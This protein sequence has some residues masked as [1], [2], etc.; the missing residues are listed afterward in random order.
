M[1]GFFE[2]SDAGW[3]CWAKDA[4]VQVVNVDAPAV[5]DAVFLA[6]HHSRSLSRLRIDEVDQ[7]VE[8]E[9][10]DQEVLLTEFLGAEAPE[11]LF[12]VLLG[13]SG[14]GKSHLVRWVLNEVKRRADSRDHIVYIAKTDMSLRRVV[15]LTIE[16]LTGPEID[17]VRRALD[18]VR[19]TV[20][21]ELAPQRLLEFL[22][23]AVA[24]A[25]KADGPRASSQFLKD[26]V[27]LARDPLFIDHLAAVPAFAAHARQ[28]VAGS[29]SPSEDP[30]FQFT[31][32]VLP[33]RASMEDA[34]RKA[35]EAGSRHLTN[36]DAREKLCQVFNEFQPAAIRGMVGLGG[37]SLLQLFSEVRRLLASGKKGGKRLLLFIEDLTVL[38]GIEHEFAD[39]LTVPSTTR[40]R[41]CELR[42]LAASTDEN[43]LNSPFWTMQTVRTRAAS[44]GSA[45]VLDQTWERFGEH[46]L[47]L[48]LG[49]YLN[50]VRVGV[51]GLAHAL[52]AGTPDDDWVPNACRECPQSRT[53]H[54]L[55]GKGGSYGL[56]PMNPDA[57]LRIRDLIGADFD[58][59]KLLSGTREA[60]GIENRQLLL[61]GQF[62]PPALDV[63]FRK[64]EIKAGQG[65]RI[66][67]LSRIQE[68]YPPDARRRVVTFVEFWGRSAPSKQLGRI[69]QAFGLDISPLLTN[70]PPPPPPPPTPWPPPPPPPAVN[71]LMQAIERWRQGT[72]LSSDH[73]G[74][75]RALVFEH[76]RD[77][78]TS[79]E[80]LAPS[81][82]TEWIKGK[83]GQFLNLH[84]VVLHEAAGGGRDTAGLWSI[85]LRPS[86]L[87]DVRLLFGLVQYDISGHWHFIDGPS[88]FRLYRERFDTW[89]N[90][91]VDMIHRGGSSNSTPILETLASVLVAGSVILGLAE[92]PPSDP[93][94]RL[95]LALSDGT[96]SS[97][98]TDEWGNPLQLHLSGPDP[99]GKRW[100]RKRLLEEVLGRIGVRQGTSGRFRAIDGVELEA[101][102][103]RFPLRKLPTA[104]D[105]LPEG[106]RSYWRR[107]PQLVSDS[108]DWDHS[109]VLR[110][111]KK[112]TESLMR[113]VGDVTEFPALLDAMDGLV[114][115]A[116][117]AGVLGGVTSRTEWQRTHSGLD[118]CFDEL[119]S[120]VRG[121]A[122]YS[123]LSFWHRVMYLAH[124]YGP[125]L[126]KAADAASQCLT[127]FEATRENLTRESRRTGSNVGVRDGLEGLLI[128]L[129]SAID[130]FEG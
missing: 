126:Q 98:R 34:G 15:E 90:D 33:T 94:H 37:T 27:D 115:A 13:K 111:W 85:D 62:P 44:S 41:L 55:F 65:L 125:P 47:E 86:E 3:V 89:T 124:D 109:H 120:A 68:A 83:G 45:F 5:D 81:G 21:P 77:L 107:I 4:P 42:V 30:A 50:A 56:Y 18:E 76:L 108:L 67:L 22:M 54:E 51:D 88:Y 25:T 73:A 79:A 105:D 20:P 119:A 57:L 17:K 103:E 129:K 113:I 93:I 110:E 8:G 38:S 52:H 29:R 74:Q 16:G 97:R 121:L 61:T 118:G 48:F 66:D 102:L 104:S 58:P 2:K 127:V 26:V 36:A 10:A 82:A 63:A 101:A 23:M 87:N 1:S 9:V 19:K 130:I 32:D 116:L 70:A 64:H 84:S 92:S 53:C 91:L 106:L 49:R 72:P 43:Y 71:S 60:L 40:Q 28:L 80:A 12:L 95:S 114:E 100:D 46:E 69:G 122:E 35:R 117:E 112:H 7:G 78:V 123:E 75:L 31:P 59:R 14:T 39:A 6:T 11:L 128:E 96:T 99:N 24:D